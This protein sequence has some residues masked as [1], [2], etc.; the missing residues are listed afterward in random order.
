MSVY[1]CLLE[2]S[3]RYTKI[4]RY[5]HTYRDGGLRALRGLIRVGVGNDEAHSWMHCS[6]KRGVSPPT[7]VVMEQQLKSRERVIII[8]C[9]SGDLTAGSS[10]APVLVVQEIAPDKHTLMRTHIHTSFS[11]H[12]RVGSVYLHTHTREKPKCEQKTRLFGIVGLV[13][14]TYLG[15]YSVHYTLIWNHWSEWT[16]HW[17]QRYF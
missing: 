8:G 16:T 11:A 6:P 7:L 5:P 4:S 10:L 14:W 17:Q 9:D 2:K 15:E 3:D 1:W 13:C 12:L